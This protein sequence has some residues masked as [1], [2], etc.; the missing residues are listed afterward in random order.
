M[1]RFALC[2]LALTF[3][4]APRTTHAQEP[5][6]ARRDIE[7]LDR[8]LADFSRGALP[9]PA[10]DPL[11][12]PSW[13]PERGFE[14]LVVDLMRRDPHPQPPVRISYARV[15]LSAYLGELTGLAVGAL[16]GLLGAAVHGCENGE[17]WLEGYTCFAG[18]GHAAAMGALIAMPV[19]TVTGIGVGAAMSGYPEL[20]GDALGGALL[21][22]LPG[23][24][25]LA[26]YGFTY[27]LSLMFL[28]S[29]AVPAGLSPLISTAFY[30]DAAKRRPGF[31]MT[32]F[33]RGV[34]A[35][36][37]LGVSGRF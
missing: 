7:R 13:R 3:L 25:G 22:T 17:G 14:T 30:V 8:F 2:A 19:G 1:L 9:A 24:M 18:H 37:E 10:P 11:A 35:G 20:V 29:F 6:D 23:V 5:R 26:S 31:V 28:L 32:P 27:D 15:L 36:A 21:G 33:V 34:A 4:C 12:P 16:G